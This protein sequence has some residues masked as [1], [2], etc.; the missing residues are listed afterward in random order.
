MP[1]DYVIQIQ[2]TIYYGDYSERFLELIQSYLET[3]LGTENNTISTGLLFYVPS[4]FVT[5]ICTVNQ[6]VPRIV[7][8]VELF[9]FVVLFENEDCH[10][11]VSSYIRMILCM[12][13][14]ILFTQ[15]MKNCVQK[16][17]TSMS[18]SGPKRVSREESG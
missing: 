10:C 8:R 4:F 17:F 16:C 7:Q 3:S 2:E 5:V 9:E 11:M 6:M 15:K 18:Y 12:L 13:W 14:A 1:E